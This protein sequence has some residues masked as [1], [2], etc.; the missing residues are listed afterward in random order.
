MDGKRLPIMRR[1]F[2]PGKNKPCQ[3][4][5]T[6]EHMAAMAI[7]AKCWRLWRQKVASR[8]NA[9]WKSCNSWLFRAKQERKLHNKSSA[10]KEL[11]AFIFWEVLLLVGASL[12]QRVLLTRPWLQERRD[13][14]VTKLQ[15]RIANAFEALP[16]M[17]SCFLRSSKT[18]QNGG[19]SW[20]HGGN[21]HYCKMLE[22]LATKSG[23]QRQCVLEILATVDSSW[24]TKSVDCTLRVL[25]TKGTGCFYLLGS[26]ASWDSC[27]EFPPVDEWIALLHWS[28]LGPNQDRYMDALLFP[29]K[30]PGLPLLETKP[31]QSTRARTA[32]HWSGNGKY[33]QNSWRLWRQ[34]W[35]AEAEAMRFENLATAD[36]LGQKRSG[37]CTLRASLTQGTG[38]FQLLQCA[39]QWSLTSHCRS[40]ECQN[41]WG[42]AVESQC[43]SDIS[44]CSRAKGSKPSNGAVLRSLPSWKKQGGSANRQTMIWIHQRHD[45]PM[46]GRCLRR[47]LCFRPRAPVLESAPA[48]LPVLGIHQDWSPY[49]YLNRFWKKK[50]VCFH[51]FGQKG[52]DFNSLGYVMMCVPLILAGEMNLLPKPFKKFSHNLPT[53]S[54][55][56]TSLKNPFTRNSL[57]ELYQIL[58]RTYPPKIELEDV[59]TEFTYATSTAF[60]NSCVSLMSR[61]QWDLR[62]CNVFFTS[63][64]LSRKTTPESSQVLHLPGKWHQGSLSAVKVSYDDSIKNWRLR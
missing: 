6:A 41:R 35:P 29:S 16:I 22:T 19:H 15:K 37:N 46:V 63:I 25:L 31:K 8:G 28:R 64:V 3:S 49:L 4:G 57:E 2:L 18:F 47:S 44:E 9:F 40:R 50:Y 53:R 1:S 13:L 61:L 30:K 48:G 62:F 60:R 45:G 17:C 33:R 51:P 10:D 21:G 12:T 39:T 26:P 23:Q 14:N 42:W 20:A 54:L 43:I 24:E 5:A 59:K 34:K 55:D 27:G 32:V 7:V 11:V 58:V 52:S 56:K 36:S 38:C